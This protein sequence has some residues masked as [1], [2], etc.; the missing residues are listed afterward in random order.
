MEKRT[1]VKNNNEI[2]KQ[3]SSFEISEYQE[4]ILN[5]EDEEAR[6]EVL[7]EIESSRYVPP[8][9]E[10]VIV[11]EDILQNKLPANHKFIYASVTLPNKFGIINCRNEKEEHIQIRFE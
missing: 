2:W 3:L 6:I 7:N 5:G 9:E 8:A 4:N 1:L 11:A 10:D